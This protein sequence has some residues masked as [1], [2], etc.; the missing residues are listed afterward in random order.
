MGVAHVEGDLRGPAVD[1]VVAPHGAQLAGGRF[2]DDERDPFAVVHGGEAFQLRGRQGTP[3]AEEAEEA[4]LL[5]LGEVEA[6]ERLGVRGEDGA[7][8][9]RRAVPRHDVRLPVARIRVRHAHHPIRRVAFV[10]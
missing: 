8:V 9:H 4:A 1:G 5:R 10:P 2:G 3:V 7:N 6:L